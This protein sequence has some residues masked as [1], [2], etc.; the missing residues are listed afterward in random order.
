MILR[1]YQ[2]NL[3]EKIRLAFLNKFK[4]LCVVAPT[5]AGKTII[6]SHIVSGAERKGNQILILCHRKELIDQI[7]TALN[8][9]NVSHSFIAAS[10]HYDKGSKVHIASVMTLI[11]RLDSIP[12]PDLIIIDECSHAIKNN[13]WGKVINFY[14]D[15]KKIGVTATPE[16]L[17]GKPLKDSF[18]RLVL[19]PSTKELITKGYLSNY[20]IYAPAS[21]LDLSSVKKSQGDYVTSQIFDAV[22]KRV[23]TGDAIDEYK[24]YAG[25]KRAVVFCVTRE[26]AYSV[27]SQFK[28]AGLE[29]EVLLGNTPDK[30]RDGRVKD[31]RAG[32][33]KI[34][35]TV[36]IIT[37]GFDLP[38]IECI[39]MLRPTLSLSLYLQIVGR[40]L[41]PFPGKEC[42]IILDQVSNYLRH[43]LPDSKRDWSLE[44]RERNKASASPELQVKKCPKC[45]YVMLASELMCPGCH[46]FFPRK[47]S[48]IEQV[49]GELTE[50]T[51]DMVREM[52]LA[53]KREQAEAQTV[54]ELTELG[55]SRGYKNPHGWA[56]HVFRARESRNKRCPEKKEIS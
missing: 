36:E 24:K 6:F 43:G 35:I 41:R 17:D 3:I 44:G 51:E 15:S 54:F 2:V 9:F 33:I 4:S 28:E 30:I 39:I 55:K 21:D 34:L 18:D 52:R 5:G 12:K 8:H 11:N 14:Q 22:N 45:F 20:R 42:A 53:R 46:Y 10:R 40:A 16:R 27:S 13:S 48:K 49:E 47:E 31:F 56:K 29:A 19:G 38:A 26:H 7:S 37:E 32:R 25:G 1:D 50:V 23:I